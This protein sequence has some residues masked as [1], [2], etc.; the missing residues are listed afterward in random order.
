MLSESPK[1]HDMQVRVHCEV[2]TPAW[3]FLKQLTK[4]RVFLRYF[5]LIAGFAH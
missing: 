4:C 2:S 1:T 5:D 3:L